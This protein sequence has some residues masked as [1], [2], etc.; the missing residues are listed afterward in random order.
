MPCFGP[1]AV[2]L[3]WNFLWINLTAPF[4]GALAGVVFWKVIETPLE[5][6]A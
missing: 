3:K 1:A 6:P 2:A 5:N 4:A